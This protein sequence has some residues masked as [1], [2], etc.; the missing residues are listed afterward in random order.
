MVDVDDIV[1]LKSGGP[2]M[3]VEYVFQDD[4]SREKAA[5]LRGFAEGDVVCTWQHTLPTGSSKVMR[6]T[7]KAATL[8]DD[9]GNP[10]S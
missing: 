6:E 7:F 8:V 9:T 3:V 2:D 4:G 5:A 1:R 10:I